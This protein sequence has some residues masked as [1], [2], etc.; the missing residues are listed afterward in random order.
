MQF[1]LTTSFLC[2]Y[3]ILYTFAFEFQFVVFAP[4]PGDRR[5]RR[6]FGHK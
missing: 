6:R 4:T 5:L 1:F 2:I 3:D